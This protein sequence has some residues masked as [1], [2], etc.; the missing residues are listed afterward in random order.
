[1]SVVNTGPLPSLSP[2]GKIAILIAVFMAGILVAVL[3]NK[4]G[5]A[6]KPEAAITSADDGQQSAPS[7]S[8]AGDQASVARG[9]QIYSQNGFTV[10]LNSYSKKPNIDPLTAKEGSD[11]L[12]FLAYSFYEEAVRCAQVGDSSQAGDSCLVFADRELAFHRWTAK[13]PITDSAAFSFF[14][15][16]AKAGIPPWRNQGLTRAPRNPP[17][18]IS[19]VEVR[20]PEIPLRNPKGIEVEIRVFFD[21]ERGREELPGSIG[22]KNFELRLDA[23]GWYVASNKFDENR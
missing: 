2:V 5:P 23:A 7:T 11:I 17:P 4:G 21:P 8:V 9:Q 10:S 6:A 12:A 13:W 15:G 20:L 18:P 22:F 19:R 14:F 3:V 16:V 1:M